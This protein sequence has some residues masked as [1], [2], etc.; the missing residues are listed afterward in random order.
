MKHIE[1]TQSE[2]NILT[3]AMDEG[4]I[5]GCSYRIEVRHGNNGKLLVLLPNNKETED[6]LIKFKK[7]FL[8]G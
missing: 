7:D 5:F 2:M 4:I 3:A 6:I 1:F 8:E